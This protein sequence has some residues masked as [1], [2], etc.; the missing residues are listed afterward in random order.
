MNILNIE[1]IS[2]TYGDKVIFD[3]ISLG[4]HSK[5]KIGVIGVNGTG[6]TTLLKMIAGLESKDAGEIICSNGKTIAYLPQNPEFPEEGSILSYVVKGKKDKDWDVESQAKTILTKLG[7]YECE[8]S[9]KN[10]SGGEK[11]RVA[12]ARTLVAPADILILDEPTNHIDNDMV[13]WLEEFLL[14]FKGVLIMVTHDRFFLDRVTNKI[15]E[16]DHGKL[17]SYDANY[18]GF[19][20]LKTQREEM[21]IATE[22]KRQSI[23][24]VEK[25]WIMRGPQGRGTKQ[26]ARKERYERLLNA[27]GSRE[28][29]SV[30]MDSVE[31][32]L[33]KKTIEVNNISKS[34]GEKLLVKDFTHIFLR[35]ERIGIIGKNGAGKSTLIKILIGMEQ[36]DGGSVDLGETVKVGYFAQ[37]CESMKEDIRVID[38]IKDVADYIQTATGQTSASQMLE[39]FLFTPEMQYTPIEKLS[40]GER[41]RLYLLR[42]L[43]EAPNV[44]ILDEPTNDL[45]IETLTILEDYLDSFRGIVIT[46]SHDRY[47]LD[48]VVDRILSFEGNGQLQI[49]EGG[50]TEY[51]EK[52]EE[53]QDIIIKQEKSNKKEEYRA[54]KEKKLKF[55]YMEKKEFETIDDDIESLEAKI[56]ETEEEMLTCASQYS[57][58]TELTEKKEE[59]ENQLE[60]KMERWE[61]LNDLAEK[62]ENQ[63]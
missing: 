31:S 35:N 53:E 13:R 46:V 40:G 55:T 28:K 25:E 63:D 5:D 3:D 16:I 24:R 4:I 59:L 48:R 8:C 38:Y 18:S 15:V 52:K 22:R 54:S 12:L 43:M 50:Y 32:R 6:K 1:H 61:Y 17:Y 62:I 30:E 45:D 10:L 19:L 57:K 7:I 29:Q 21:E 37:E 39:R 14:K 27:S 49:Y 58:L 33:G 36:P 2:K 56:Q 26:R 23:L 11:K 44:L 41:R 42:V 47:F 60:L 34:F 51:M 9:T 20:D